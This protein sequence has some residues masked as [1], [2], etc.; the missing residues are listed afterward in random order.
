MRNQKTISAIGL[1]LAAVAFLSGCGGTSYRADEEDSVIQNA[2]GTSTSGGSFTGG[3]SSGSS[4]SSSVSGTFVP[5]WSDDFSVTGS[6]GS[7]PSYTTDVISTDNLLNVKIIARGAG[8]ISYPGYSNASA[9]Y[10]CIEYK[11]QVINA[12]TNG[13]I[14][15]SVTTSTMAV[16]GGSSSCSGA[17]GEQTIDLSSRVGPGHPPVKIK[18]EATRYDYYCQIWTSCNYNYSYYIYNQTMCYYS[19]P[20]YM[21]GSYCPLRTIYQTHT[22]QGTIEVQVNGTGL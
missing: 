20:F 12:N 4:S 16:D 7:S 8:Q 19:F 13:N 15:A 14:G 18:V 6:G 9:Q 17:A 5:A 2:D 11:V 3:S 10:K 1:S 22:V 21:Q